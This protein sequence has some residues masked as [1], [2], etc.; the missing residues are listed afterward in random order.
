[1]SKAYK[2]N[3][4]IKNMNSWKLGTQI[5]R[6]DGQVYELM[7]AAG[8]KRKFGRLGNKKNQQRF[9]TYNNMKHTFEV[10]EQDID[11]Q[12][13]EEYKSEYTRDLSMID[14]ETYINNVI[15]AAIKKLDRKIRE[16]R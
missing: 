1:M 6:D 15:L 16:E 4:V 13:I 9:M 10:V 7:K 5:K 2:F 14:M 3:E 11:I 8:G 12:S